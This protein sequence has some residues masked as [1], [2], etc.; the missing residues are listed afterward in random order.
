MMFDAQ[1]G[2]RTY[3][4]EVKTENAAMRATVDGKPVEVSAVWLSPHTIHLIV[5]GRSYDL[6]VVGQGNEYHVSTR[7]RTHDIELRAATEG[8]SAAARKK[9]AGPAAIRAPM[10]GKIVRLL[11]EDGQNVADGTGLLVIEAMKMENEI[12][13]PR[14]G[15][16]R[17]I[18]VREGQTV[19]TGATLCVL[20]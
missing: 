8:A 10:P 15:H 3:R 9:P 6:S 1:L 16:V 20:E 11:V 7:R 5:D 19:E 4:I 2:E 17:G 13:S 18:A 14:A 12:R